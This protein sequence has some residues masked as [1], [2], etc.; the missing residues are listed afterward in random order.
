MTRVELVFVSALALGLV[1]LCHA[2]LEPAP[3][4][5]LTGVASGAASLLTRRRASLGRGL[6]A[7]AVGAAV[8]LVPHLVTHLRGRRPEPV[9]GLARH[10]AVDG[11]LGFALAVAVLA[12]AVGLLR[13]KRYAR[14]R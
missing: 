9:E 3:L 6:V 10:L 14:S 8:G 5:A 2:V 1:A 13:L 11:L 12:V 4:P 7:V